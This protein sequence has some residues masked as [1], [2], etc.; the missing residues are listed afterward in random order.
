MVRECVLVN[1]RVCRV[2]AVRGACG[3]PGSERGA[4]ESELRWMRR[5]AML[6]PCG[7]GRVELESLGEWCAWG[8]GRAGG[9]RHVRRANGSWNVDER[10]LRTKRDSR[11]GGGTRPLSSPCAPQVISAGS[12]LS[13]RGPT[14]RSNWLHGFPRH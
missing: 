14:H 11:D 2:S 9:G 7:Q 6:Q 3:A 12:V 1:A 8:A 5:R 13:S 10:V 4:V